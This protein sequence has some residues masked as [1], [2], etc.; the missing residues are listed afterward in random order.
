VSIG[1]G[2]HAKR[3]HLDYFQA[4]FCQKCLYLSYAHSFVTSAP[5]E[6]G[7]SVSRASRVLV[8]VEDEEAVVIKV[9]AEHAHG[10]HTQFRFGIWEKAKGRDQVELAIAKY[11]ALC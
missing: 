3:I 9:S 4:V 2:E 5:N 6:S 11:I 1:C 10:F 8:V 7:K